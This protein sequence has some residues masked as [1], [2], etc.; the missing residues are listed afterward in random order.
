MTTTERDTRQLSELI[1]DQL[2]PI[3]ARYWNDIQDFATEIREG[4]IDCNDG[5]IA[6]DCDD[7]I[8]RV[9]ETC[10][11]SEWTIYTRNAYIVALVSDNADAG[12][13]SLGESILETDVDTSVTRAA[14]FAMVADMLAELARDSG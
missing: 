6:R 9:E 2:R 14:Y 1:S 5:G 7:C 13:D 10:D 3:R 11:G 8:Q 12:V 4:H